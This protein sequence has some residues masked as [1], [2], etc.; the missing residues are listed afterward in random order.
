M[1][2]S[3]IP[4][5]AAYLGA[6]LLITPAAGRAPEAPSNTGGESAILEDLPMVE[7]ATLHSQ[8]LQEAPAA[9]TVI[10][11]SEIRRYGYRT[12]ADVLGA[13]RGF[14]ITSDRSYQYAGIRGLAI[15]GD[16]NSRFLIMI[17]GHP[18]TE[19]IYNSTNF[20][21]QDFGLDMDLV[22]RIEIIRGPVS[23][24]YG[25]NGILANI[26]IVT[27]SPVDAAQFRSTLETG[28]FGE[29]KATM[30]S[31]LDLGRGANLLLSAS[32]F[33]NAGRR[34][35]FEDYDSPE[36]NHGIANRVDA[37]R[38]YHTFA[39][40]VWGRWNVLGYFNSRQAQV[41]VAGIGIIF[42]DPA[43][44][45]LDSRNFLGVIYNR[46]AG[47]T[48]KLRWQLY[49]DRYRYLDRW[50]YESEEAGGVLDNRTGAWGDW[51]NS[52]L[53]YS[54]PLGRLGTLTAGTEGSVE[55]RNLQINE[56]VSPNYFQ[57]LSISRPDRAVAVFGQQE[58]PLG[59]RWTAY[60]GVRMDQSMNFGSFASPRLALVF[61]PSSHTA[62]KLVYGRPFRNPSVFERYYQDNLAYL[63]N[64]NL[65]QERAHALEVSAERRLK[66]NFSVILNAFHYRF[67]DIIQARWITD[68]LQQY[69]NAGG[70]RSTGL[71]M[72]LRAAPLRWLETDASLVV[73]KAA[74]AGSGARLP[75]SPARIHK[76]RFSIPF[77]GRRVF[78]S[79]AFQYISP[80]VTGLGIPLRRV[81]L[82][83][84]TLSTVRLSAS[85]DLVGGVRNLLNWQYHHPVD[86]SMDRI[87][88]NGRTFFVKLI[89]R[90]LE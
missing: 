87:L 60:L 28:S 14:Y 38:G 7:A 11:A 3:Q 84:T 2:S 24:L 51:L 35:Y 53:I 34:L 56:D 40:F 16:W 41:P 63:D 17:N 66:P 73:Q 32:V 58:V 49:Y 86:Y 62:Y 67:S 89:W 48:G 76:G 80:R 81:F 68:T 79:G 39:N 88:A 61:Q 78:A 31:S 9:V 42:N 59:R 10:T 82:A 25:S 50:D 70:R 47:A 69:Q 6:A 46:E 85:Y 21:G 18:L 19:N 4:A 55:L 8:T 44:Y 27:H 20:F 77:A 72:E 5:L 65:F 26:N 64:P 37:E 45:A 52:Q 83:D 43:N 71:E 15:P 90:P 33:H 12:L 1:R 74:E 22:N 36:T 57:H 13:V 30:S 23:A 29:K 75:N 54:R